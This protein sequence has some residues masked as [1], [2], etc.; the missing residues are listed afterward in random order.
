M[1][2]PLELLWKPTGQRHP[3]S[4]FGYPGQ[5]ELR[6]KSCRTSAGALSSFIL[7]QHL[8]KIEHARH[9]R[10][11]GYHRGESLA[12][13]A[14]SEELDQLNPRTRSIPRTISGERS[15][16]LAYAAG[17]QAAGRHAR[18][19]L[20]PGGRRDEGDRGE[21]W[22]WHRRNHHCPWIAT[23]GVPAGACW[24]PSLAGALRPE[25]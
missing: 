9:G 1:T 25:D 20:I 6:P 5:Q 22:L 12:V 16:S 8:Q 3:H 18:Q 21:V 17:S 19:V 14:L 13:E 15:R 10:Q 11:R 7:A 4:A 2:P 23:A 24:D